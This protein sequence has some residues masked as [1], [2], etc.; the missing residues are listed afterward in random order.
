MGFVQRFS[1][2]L[3]EWARLV[4]LGRSRTAGLVRVI[5]L[6]VGLGIAVRVTS[7][8]QGDI[9]LFGSTHHWKQPLGWVI[10]AGGL[11]LWAFVACGAAWVHTRGASL[12]LDKRLTADPSA[13]C[14]RLRLWN[15]GTATRPEVQVTHVIDE[16]GTWLV[17]QTQPPFEVPWSHEPPGQRALLSAAHKEGKTVGVLLTYLMSSGPPRLRIFGVGNHQPWVNN[18][19]APNFKFFMRL[20]AQTPEFLH[21]TTAVSVWYSVTPDTGVP[22]GFQTIREKPSGKGWPR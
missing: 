6:L 5:G 15:N 11:V 17:D 3:S 14:F 18:G 20:V 2:F 19:Q 1:R 12:R 7:P 10:A 8:V 16:Q 22:L 4:A 21:A 9:T 13:N